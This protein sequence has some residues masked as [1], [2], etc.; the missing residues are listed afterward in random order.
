M[1]DVHFTAMFSLYLP[2]CCAALVFH[3]RSLVLNADESTRLRRLRESPVEP[4]L[5]PLRLVR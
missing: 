1:L 2:L 3:I 4:R 5:L